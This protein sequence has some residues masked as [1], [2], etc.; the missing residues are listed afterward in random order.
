MGPMGLITYF[1]LSFFFFYSERSQVGTLSAGEAQAA[2]VTVLSLAPADLWYR[3]VSGYISRS[4]A[5][6]RAG[7]G[8]SGYLLYVLY[9][10]CPPFLSASPHLWREGEVFL[11]IR[12]PYIVIL[13][14]MCVQYLFVFSASS[15]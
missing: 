15:A 1:F 5:R 3:R 10:Y 12:T 14:P 8:G 6:G 11:V 4:L 2:S 7:G 13:L 9:I